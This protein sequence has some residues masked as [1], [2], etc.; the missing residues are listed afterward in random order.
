ME[1]A[2]RAYH[3]GNLRATLLDAALDLAREGGPDAVVLREAS[4]RA[5][6]SH[7]AAYR[8]FADRDALLQAVCETGMAALSDQLVAAIEAAHARPMSK[9]GARK[10]L[11]ACGRGYVEFALA[12]P[13]LFRTAFAVPDRLPTDGDV[14]PHG[15]R[16][17]Y[18]ILG[19]CLDDLVSSGALP[20]RRRPYAEFPAWSAV[21]GYAVLLLDGPLRSLPRGARDE[22]LERVVTSV[23]DGL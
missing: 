23:L 1:V 19:A 6:V 15:G 10:R 20:A 5:G 12:Q 4:R 16:S 13:G 18:E 21:H 3:H 17:P 7:N 2:E 8:H 22:G 9:A 11:L 14:G